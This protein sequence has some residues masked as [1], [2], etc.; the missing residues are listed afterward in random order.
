MDLYVPSLKHAIL[1][2]WG[3]GNIWA[4]DT[5][6][7]VYKTIIKEERKCLICNYTYISNLY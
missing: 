2:I 5:S 7:T 3:K 6:Q 1:H 4:R